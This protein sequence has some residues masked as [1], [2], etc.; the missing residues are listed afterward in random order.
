MSKTAIGITGAIVAA[1]LAVLLVVQ[2]QT[3]KELRQEIETLKQQVAQFAPLQEQL[4]HATQEA[5]SASGS[6]EAQKHELARLRAEVSKLRGQSK[7][8]SEAQQETQKLNECLASTTENLK[9][10]SAALKEEIQKKQST[11]SVQHINACINNLRLIDSAKQQ[12][13]IEN[14]RQL[15]DTPT[16]DD[17]LPYFGPGPNNTNAPSCP[18]A[19]VYTIGPGSEKPT[20]SI[21][22]HVLP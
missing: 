10:Q 6:A 22:G 20:C 8:L 2:Q 7:E 5:A 12:W 3:I 19:G 21:A 14:K 11:E 9:G 15:T 16:M 1:T 18:D 13:A 17:L 4:D